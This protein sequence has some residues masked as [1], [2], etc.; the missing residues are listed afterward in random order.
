LFNR[1]GH[2]LAARLR[3]ANVHSADGWEAMLPPKIRREVGGE[4][5]KLLSAER[6]DSCKLRC[7][8]SHLNLSVSSFNP[9]FDLFAQAWE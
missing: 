4:K 6:L 1:Q 8:I 9:Q 2:C 3:L 7:A 5:R